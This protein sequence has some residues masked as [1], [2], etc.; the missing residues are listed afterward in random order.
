MNR[1]VFLQRA[2]TFALVASSGTRLAAASNLPWGK[3]G[4]QL[5]G[6]VVLPGDDGFLALARP[7]NL[8]YALRQPK[9]IALCANADD[10]AASILW[11]REYGVPLVARSGGHSYAGYS[12]TTGLMIDVAQM[13]DFAF[14][15]STGIATV[16][17]GARNKHVYAECR[18][19]GVAITH[20][21]CAEVGIAGLSLGGGVGFNMRAH[22]LLCD[23]MVES[24]IVTADGSIRTMNRSKNTDLFWACRGAGG[25]NFG[26]NTS[27]SFQTFNVGHVT[28]YD[29]SWDTDLERVFE[30]LVA[31]LETTPAR[32]GCKVSIAAS[33]SAGGGV[34]KLQVQLLGQLVGSTSEL[35]EI[36][37]PVYALHPPSQTALLKELP[38]WDAQDKL[39]EIGAPSYFQERSRFLD[40]RFSHTAIETIFS[41]LRRWP[42]TTDSAAFKA[43]QTGGRINA[44]PR[45]ATAFAHRE[46]QWLGSVDVIWN[47]QTASDVLRRNLA[48]Q[49]GFYDALI[50]I[51]KGGA[52]QNFA[53]PSLK[54]WET[55]YYRSNLP[56]LEAVKLRVDPARVF[57]FPEA[58]RS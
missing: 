55:A 26:I 29:L 21:R 32:L 4:K 35:M 46:S 54:D 28:A 24:E 38:Y 50:P 33:P 58:I 34:P 11:A 17:G 12:T 30:R 2:S 9:G 6:R 3:L 22:G 52:Y 20:G 5:A 49:S 27:L 23:Q 13:N 43:F 48:W 18:R 56:R 45:G 42:A 19:L 10:V 14:D 31:A 40:D 8:R 47:G 41:W 15:P 7:N 44:V 57:A 16:G 36:L 39:S 53:D 51:A 1:R 37:H 25:G